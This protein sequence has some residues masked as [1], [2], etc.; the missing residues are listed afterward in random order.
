[1]VICRTGEI[2]LSATFYTRFMISGI[3]YEVTDSFNVRSS[4]ESGESY[5]DRECLE[6][7]IASFDRL[8]GEQD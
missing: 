6:M 7:A 5:T 2:E 4:F 1:M 3:R 8:A